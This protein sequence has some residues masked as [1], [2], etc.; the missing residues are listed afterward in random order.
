M[1]NETLLNMDLVAMCAE[2]RCEEATD[3]YISERCTR[4]ACPCAQDMLSCG[5]CLKQFLVYSSL[6]SCDPKNQ[7]ALNIYETWMSEQKKKHPKSQLA[8]N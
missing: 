4:D 5:M 1:E 2:G 6:S 8:D 3:L 7:Q